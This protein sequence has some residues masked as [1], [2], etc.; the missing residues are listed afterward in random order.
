MIVSS[1]SHRT[2]SI[3]GRIHA[4]GFA[5]LKPLAAIHLWNR[6]GARAH[7]LA[8]ELRALR[9]QFA[10]TEVDIRVDDTVAACVQSA[11]IVVTATYAS[12]PLV[13]IAMLGKQRVHINGMR[14][15][16]LRIAFLPALNVSFDLLF[17]LC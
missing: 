5:T 10:S 1:A 11:D 17:F 8:E 15:A 7:Q 13:A 2:A 6:T 9:S 14:D 12:E 16:F 3:Q 4:I